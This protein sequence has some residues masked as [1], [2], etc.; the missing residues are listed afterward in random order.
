MPTAATTADD[1]PCGMIKAETSGR[2]PVCDS[3]APGEGVARCK[4]SRRG[5]ANNR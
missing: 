3:R 1:S 4:G 5:L 2:L